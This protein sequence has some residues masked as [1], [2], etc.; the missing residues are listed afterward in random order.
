[1]I[2]SRMNYMIEQMEYMILKNEHRVI[3]DYEIAHG[4]CCKAIRGNHFEH[5][6]TAVH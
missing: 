3:R 1:L 5:K 2:W 4:G 6:K